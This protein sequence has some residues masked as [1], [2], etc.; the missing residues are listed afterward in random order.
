ML[1]LILY[2]IP[3]V[4]KFFDSFGLTQGWIVIPSM[5]VGIIL[6]IPSVKQARH[7]LP[8]HEDIGVL[9]FGL[10]LMFFFLSWPIT[11]FLIVILLIYVAF[12]VLKDE[13]KLYK[14][15]V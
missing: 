12:L 15:E 14:R 13:S 11:I 2:L 6:I 3:F 10:G 1:Y 5:A 7:H 4:A 9:P 8:D